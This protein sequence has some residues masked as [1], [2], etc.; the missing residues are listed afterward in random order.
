M[1]EILECS[2]GPNNPNPLER[3]SQVFQSLDPTDSTLER[4]YLESEH[5]R[6]IASHTRLLLRNADANTRCPVRDDLTNMTRSST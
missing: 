5:L 4:V 2:V 3:E 6:Q 1:L